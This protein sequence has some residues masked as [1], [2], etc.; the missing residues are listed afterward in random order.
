MT[1]TSV[2]NE[3]VKYWI[4]LRKNK[5]MKEEKK[6]IVETAHLVE[7]ALKSQ[8]VDEIIILENEKLNISCDVKVNVVSERVMNKISLLTTSP[9][10]MAVCNFKEEKNLGDKIVILDDVKDPGNVGNIIRNSVAFGVDSVILSEESVNKYN[11]KLIRATQGMFFK[12][13]IVQDDIIKQIKEIKKRNIDL[14]A[15]SLK[16]SDNLTSLGKLNKYAVVF[17]NEAKG[18]SKDVEKLCDKLIRININSVCDSLN[19]SSTS[20]IVLYY[21]EG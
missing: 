7:E 18:I 14:I 13:N 19:V 21:L 3:L 6:Y 20:A 11:D 8:I 2:N 9:K 17:G 5:Y 16:A 12:I 1:I 10:I 15:T 4:K